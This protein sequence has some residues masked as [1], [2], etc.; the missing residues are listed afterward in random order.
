MSRLREALDL[1]AAG[2][3]LGAHAVVRDD[4]SAEAAWIHAPLHRV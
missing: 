3:W 1:M 2:D 4:A